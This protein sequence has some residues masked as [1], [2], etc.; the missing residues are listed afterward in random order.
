MLELRGSRASVLVQDTYHW[1]SSGGLMLLGVLAILCQGTLTD[2]PGSHDA[3]KQGDEGDE[4]RRTSELRSLSPLFCGLC[5]V[6]TGE[7]GIDA[8]M[9]VSSVPGHRPGRRSS[10]GGIADSGATQAYCLR[11]GCVSAG[12]T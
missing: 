12:R 4:A 1:D 8:A 3:V 5:V 7:G 6:E 2:G 10:P 9:G 11:G